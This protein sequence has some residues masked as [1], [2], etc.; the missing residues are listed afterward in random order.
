M[1]QAEFAAELG[2][3]KAAYAA[4]ESG[5]NEPRTILATARRIEALSGVP[6]VWL[7][8]MDDGAATTSRSSRRSHLAL[9]T[10]PQVS[11]SPHA[12]AAVAHLHQA[13]AA[14]GHSKLRQTA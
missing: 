2:V 9:V 1:E 5:R 13:E 3:T 10:H 14:E 7:L 6:A 12:D 11:A 8:G 4:W